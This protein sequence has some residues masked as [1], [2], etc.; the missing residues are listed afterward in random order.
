MEDG[1]LGISLFPY[2]A[3]LNGDF[4]INWNFAGQNQNDTTKVLFRIPSNTSTGSER[5]SA[6]VRNNRNIIQDYSQSII[7]NY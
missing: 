3:D 2:F 4:D 5:V 1:Q 6:T 7:I